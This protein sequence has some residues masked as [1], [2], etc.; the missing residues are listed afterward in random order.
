M[1]NIQKMTSAANNLFEKWST[2]TIDGLPVPETDSETSSTDMPIFR[3]TTIEFI[4]TQAVNPSRNDNLVTV[5]LV[6]LAPWPAFGKRYRVATIRMN[7]IDDWNDFSSVSCAISKSTK[8]DKFVY[9]FGIAMMIAMN[10]ENRKGHL[11]WGTEHGIRMSD[12]TKNDI[13]Y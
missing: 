6:T 13:Y 9:G 7:I 4:S 2:S 3:N 11:F 10:N 12:W 5:V 8:K 1:A